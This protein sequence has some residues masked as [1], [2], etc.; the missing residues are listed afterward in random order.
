MYASNSLNI[1]C[2]PTGLQ[3]TVCK[4]LKVPWERNKAGLCPH[5]VYNQVEEIDANPVRTQHIKL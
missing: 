5:R 2:V 3:G 1:W 4:E